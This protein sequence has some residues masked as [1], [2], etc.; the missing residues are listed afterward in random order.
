MRSFDVAVIGGGLSGLVAANLLADA[1]KSVV[2][3]EKSAQIGGRAMTIKK[4]GAL[5]NLGGH[6]LYQGGEAYAIL[7]GLGLE[8]AGNPVSTQYS[9]VWMNKV[10]P[11]PSNLPKLLTSPLITWSGKLELATLMV[12]L[13]KVDTQ[14]LMNTSLRDYTENAIRDPMVRHIFYSLCR[15]ST[16]ITDPD[17][18]IAGLVI[19][20]VQRGLKDNVLYLHGGWQTI[21]NQLRQRA[22]RSGATIVEQQRVTSIEHDGCVRALQLGEGDRIDVGCVI[23][24]ISPSDTYQLLNNASSTSLHL[25]RSEARPAYAACL[26]LSLKRLPVEKRNIALGLDLPVFFSN[27]SFSANLSDDGTSVIHLVKYNGC[28]KGDAL[29]DRRLLEDTMS[30]LHPDWRTQLVSEQFL[31]NMTIV[32]GYSHI[33]QSDRCPGPAVPEVPG[34]YVSG[35]WASHGEMLADAAVASAKRAAQ[36]VLSG[37]S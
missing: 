35:D 24:A 5:F 33:G 17:A 11:M 29:E 15:T 12:R 8:L 9:A 30:V 20:Q 27:H 36:C 37:K 3:L 10:Y 2:V 25:W 13:G 32:N 7:R 23:S 18:Q 19:R 26:D 4:G 34:L 28:K 31:P 6:A 1:G 22:T 16:Y 21:V 14:L